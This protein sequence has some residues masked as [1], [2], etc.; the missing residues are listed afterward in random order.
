MV[1]WFLVAAV[2]STYV[3]LAN[4]SSQFRSVIQYF[5][6]L[7]K[8]IEHVTLSCMIA[9]HSCSHMV[10]FYAVTL[11]ELWFFYYH[12]YLLVLIS[13]YSFRF[14]TF[15]NHGARHIVFPR[16]FRAD[17]KHNVVPGLP[18][19][20]GYWLSRQSDS[21][22]WWCHEGRGT[23]WFDKSTVLKTSAE[24]WVNLTLLC[25]YILVLCTSTWL[26]YLIISAHLCY[27]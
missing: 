15:R 1:F 18:P 27:G 26:T 7:Y 21:R 20:D 14:D 2:Y 4:T 17:F 8:I 3:V 22:D 13:I 25:A 19:C 5:I 12:A 9:M 23:A 11:L 6:D 24:F 16:W 10:S